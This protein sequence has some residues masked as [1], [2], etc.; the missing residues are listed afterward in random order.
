MKRIAPPEEWAK[1][2]CLNNPFTMNA[3]VNKC[4]LCNEHVAS[5]GRAKQVLVLATDPKNGCNKIHFMSS[6]IKG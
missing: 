5:P 3:M 2:K 6:Q 4:C 1:A